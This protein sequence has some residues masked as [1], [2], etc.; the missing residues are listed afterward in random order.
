MKENPFRKDFSDCPEREALQVLKWRG[1]KALDKVLREKKYLIFVDLEGTQFTHEMIEIGAYAVA[2]NPDGTVKK[3]AP[4]FQ[5]YVK[6]TNPIGPV[7]RN[8]TGIEEKTLKEKGISFPAAMSAFE[9]YLSKYRGKCLYVTFGNHDLCIINQSVYY[10]GDASKDFAHEINKNYLDFSDFISRYI[11]DDRGNP[12]SLTQYL[13]LFKVPFEGRA[14]DAL[15]DAYNLIDLYSAFLS[16]KDIVEREYEKTLS[17]LNHLPTPIG[18]LIKKL[19]EG[20]AVT[21]EDWKK[22]VRG[23]LE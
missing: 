14:H 12:L 13:E 7:V 21:P 8:L 4:G 3:I 5:R 15:A 18:T 20:E 17:H 6:A 1:M 23:A 11:K 22:A 9:E 2:L 16:Q 10:S 19:N